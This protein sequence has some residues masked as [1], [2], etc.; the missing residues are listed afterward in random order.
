MLDLDAIS[1]SVSYYFGMKLNFPEK[2]RFTSNQPYC[3]FLGSVFGPS[4]PQRDVRKMALGCMMTTAKWPEFD[5]A[6][7]LIKARVF[8]IFGND[9]RLNRW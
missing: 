7:E 9:C 1:E 6:T 3:H 2:Y 4:G 5:N 8:T